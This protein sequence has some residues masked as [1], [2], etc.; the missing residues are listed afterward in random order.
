MARKAQSDPDTI[1]AAPPAALSLEERRA[2]H[3]AELANL[4]AVEPVPYPAWRYHPSEQPRIV[5]SPEEDAALGK[6]WVSTPETP[7]HLGTPDE[8]AF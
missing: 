4:D 7:A 3:L 5:H 2:H 6:G 1:D 8:G